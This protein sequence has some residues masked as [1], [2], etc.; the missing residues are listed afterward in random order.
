LNKYNHSRK[1]I[2]KETNFI[3]H[4]SPEFGIEEIR[5]RSWKTLRLAPE[6]FITVVYSP[7]KA[8]TDEPTVY[9]QEIELIVNIN[10]P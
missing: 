3:G 2:D 7:D 5:S 10:K 6:A 9:T 8:D 1:L 4:L